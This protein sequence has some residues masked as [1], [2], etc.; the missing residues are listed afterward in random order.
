MIKPEMERRY[1]DCV[2]LVEQWQ[3]FRDILARCQENPDIIDPELE[4]EFLGIKARIAMLHDSFMDSLKTDRKTG[5]SMIDLVNRAITLRHHVK[6]SPVE[7]EKM[8]S[9]WHEVFMLLKETVTN[10][11]DE[12][13]RLANTN[14]FVHHSKQAVA[15]LSANSRSF[16]SSVYFKLIAGAAVLLFVIWGV[17]AFGIYDWDDLREDA[18][19][20]RPVIQNY[21]MFTREV[22]GLSAPYYSLSDFTDK[23]LHDDTP[24]GIRE[25]NRVSGDINR[26]Q[27]RQQ[28]LPRLRLWGDDA[29]RSRF[30]DLWDRAGEYDVVRYVSDNGQTGHLFLLWYRK[31]EDA[32]SFIAMRNRH[33]DRMAPDMTVEQY[34]NV[35]AIIR[36][37][38]SGHRETIRS[39]A[40]GRMKS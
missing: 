26:D 24:P 4:Q 25:Q 22:V 20:M 12:R 36:A 27:A 23:L 3:A 14:E 34:I 17:P 5:N 33:A 13:E 10:L 2:E 16:L 31:R 11:A 38:D 6:T 9:E 32:D 40:L 7:L 15:R 19:F 35:I 30:E 8:K 28:L 39:N 1:A 37:P 21:T 18:P 29:E